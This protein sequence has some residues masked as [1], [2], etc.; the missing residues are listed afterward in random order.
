MRRFHSWAVFVCSMALRP[1][2]RVATRTVYDGDQVGQA[3]AEGES[4]VACDP[5]QSSDKD[6][7]GRALASSCATFVTSYSAKPRAFAV[8]ESYATSRA[9]SW[10]DRTAHSPALPVVQELLINGRNGGKQ[11]A[12]KSG[13]IPLSYHPNQPK[14]QRNIANKRANGT[15]ARLFAIRKKPS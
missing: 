10:R 13:R 3:H 6:C 4:C 5:E 2:M 7:R 1:R 8:I 14:V 11:S 15:F 12:K 9:T